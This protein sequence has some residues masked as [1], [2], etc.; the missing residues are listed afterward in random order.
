MFE[1]LFYFEGKYSDTSGMRV[2]DVFYH[3]SW[4][5]GRS[6]VRRTSDCDSGFERTVARAF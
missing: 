5:S 2:G 1:G 3:I 4:G 6:V